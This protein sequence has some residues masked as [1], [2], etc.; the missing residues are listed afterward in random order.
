M[1]RALALARSLAVPLVA[2]AGWEAISD[3]GWVSPIVLPPPSKV[4]VRLVAY[5]LS[6]SPQIAGWLRLAR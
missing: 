5:A 1:K 6:N 3:A 4:F 2:L